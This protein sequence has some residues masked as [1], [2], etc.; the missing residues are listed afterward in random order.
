MS[1]LSTSLA[2]LTALTARLQEQKASQPSPLLVR[3]TDS[4]GPE[5]SVRVLTDDGERLRPTASFDPTPAKVRDLSVTIDGVVAGR[6]QTDVAYAECREAAELEPWSVLEE[7]RP[8]TPIE[9]MVL[10]SM[11]L[12][13]AQQRQLLDLS[14]RVTFPKAKIRYAELALRAAREI[15]R[16]ATVVHELRRPPAV[17][18]APGA[19]ANVVGG[20]QFINRG[21]GRDGG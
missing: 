7:S 10:R 3:S 5:P 1:S 15:T 14:A 9:A 13:A 16:A 17:R 12:A 21:E 4:P 2:Q 20:D 19:Q 11:A 6:L 18:V 8:R